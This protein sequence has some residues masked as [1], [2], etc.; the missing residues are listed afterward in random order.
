[1]YEIKKIAEDFKVD[2]LTNVESS[3]GDYCY[4]WMTKKNYT[5]VDAIR[6]IAEA[7]RIPKKRFGFAGSK[8]K[9]AVT[10]QLCSGYNVKKE[11]LERVKL[12]DIELEFFGQGDKPISLG[13][14]KGNKFRI[15][16]RNLDKFTIDKIVIVNYFDEQRFSENNVEIGKALVNGDFQRAVE[17]V[18]Q[19]R[20]DYN[21]RVR[22]YILESKND[23]VG[24]LKQIEKKILTIFVH[25]YQSWL[26][27]EVASEYVRLHSKE[28]KEVDYSL[29]KF[30]FPIK[31]IENVNIPVIGFG[32]EFRDEEIE[33]ISSELLRREKVVLR[34]FIIRQIPE[35]TAEGAERDL[36]VSVK[37]FDYGVGVGELN[38]G[39]NK[40]IVSFVLPKGSYA[41]IVI[42]ALVQ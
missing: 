29:G 26:W 19:G 21:Q 38:E 32:T 36:I 13:D 11:D 42:K 22:D 16:V 20:G 30:V 27:N 15:V 31:G 41:T 28:V 10:K 7:L 4:F 12:R 39:K 1:M 23:F 6:R 18:S 25:S 37:D 8:D 24:A 9:K 3:K 14:L 33:K 17:L 34:D 5:T 2:E 40:A 35:L